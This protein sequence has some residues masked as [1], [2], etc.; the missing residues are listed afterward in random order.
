MAIATYNGE[1]F[2]REQLISII[3][4]TIPVDEIVICDDGST[5]NTIDIITKVQKEI[6]INIILYKNEEKLGYI[7]N[8]HKAIEYTHGNFVFLADQDDIWKT[9]KVEIM[10]QQMKKYNCQVL[11]TNFEL[12][13]Q[14][15]NL[16]K[17]RDDYNIDAYIEKAPHEMN[18]VTV[19]RLVFGN[20][21]QGCTYCFTEKVKNLYLGINDDTVS[22]DLQIMFVGAAI[23][24]A[25]YFKMPLIQYRLHSQNAIGFDKKNI[26]DI[27]IGKISIRRIFKKPFMAIFLQRLNKQIKIKNISLYKLLFYL[28][29]PYIRHLIH[30]VWRHG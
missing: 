24:S 6:L 20:I 5:D 2:I 4:Q 12:I 27:N 9:N 21:A 25:F 11:C 23:N 7:R 22:H 15:G 18:H 19:M 13:D 3:H 30:K 29:I 10:L 28:R 1:K 26:K 14:N 16:I 8:F 17:E